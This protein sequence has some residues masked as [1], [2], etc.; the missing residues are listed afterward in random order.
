MITRFAPSPT[1][2][3]HLGHAYSALLAF[4]QAKARG[5]VFHLRIEDTDQPR[6]KP[7]WE[8]Q[9]YDDLAW[10]GLSWEEPVFRQ[11]ERAA[12]YQH[13]LDELDQM[14]LIYPCSCTRGDIRQA[15]S[16]P[17]E[18]VVNP[19]IYPG[20]CRGRRMSSRQPNDAI[21]LDMTRA[22]AGLNALTFR[23]IGPE[24]PGT[25]RVTPEMLTLE[26]GDIVLERKDI[27]AASYVLSAVV[28]DDLQNI[29]EIIRGADL[30]EITFV[31][32]LLQHLLGL[33]RPIYFHHRLIR[34]ESGKRL[35]KRDDA[36]ALS[37]Y[38]SQGLSPGDIREMVGLQ[39]AS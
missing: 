32:V 19:G 28:D 33:E 7:Y 37:L 31:Q 35:A 1:G 10:L 14:G 3:L 36:R 4:D 9:I 20:T 11:S 12:F 16:A 21:R 25:H 29:S 8:A 24:H 18:G 15:L 13:A 5:G 26:T 23:D 27:S 39:P 22:T 38:R 6:C 2:P 34:D 30:F 17:Q